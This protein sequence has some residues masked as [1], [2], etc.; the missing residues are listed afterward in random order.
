MAS[1]ILTGKMT[2]LEPEEKAKLKEQKL[3]ERFRYEMRRKGKW[4]LIL[5]WPNEDRNAKLN[6]IIV[7]A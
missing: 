6:E 1:R 4:E 3:A 7:R 5:P 2:K